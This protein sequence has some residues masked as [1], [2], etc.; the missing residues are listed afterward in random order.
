MSF[1]ESCVSVCRIETKSLL[2]DMPIFALTWQQLKGSV[3]QTETDNREL[4]K[5]NAQAEYFL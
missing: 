2:L 3:S 5:Y 1:T 4:Q